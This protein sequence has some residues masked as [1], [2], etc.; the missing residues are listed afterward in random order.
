MTRSVALL[1]S[2]L[3][4]L[5]YCEARR[6]RYFDAGLILL[7]GGWKPDSY[8]LDELGQLG[9]TRRVDIRDVL[10]LCRAEEMVIGDA[11]SGLG[12][13]AILVGRPNRV[14]FLEDGAGTFRAIE[15]FTQGQPLMRGRETSRRLKLANLVGSRLQTLETLGSLTWVTHRPPLT[16]VAGSDVHTFEGL[17]SNSIVRDGSH[18]RAVAGS[19]LASDGYIKRHRYLEWLAD[20]LSGGEDTIFYPHRRESPEALGIARERRVDTSGTSVPLERYL[21]VNKSLTDIYCLPTSI[22]LTAGVARPDIDV[23]CTP[24][25]DCWWTEDAPVSAKETCELVIR[26]LARDQPRSDEL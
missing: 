22:A 12:Q 11:Y 20:A 13:V 3:Q 2:G 6:L 9:R 19:A 16:N 8:I 17:R 14:T 24:I 10:L 5:T 15:Q 7:C 21:C 23:H 26:I 1:F 4:A 18:R 25:P